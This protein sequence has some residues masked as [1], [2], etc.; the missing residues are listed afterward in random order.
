MSIDGTFSVRRWTDE[1][2]PWTKQYSQF[3]RSIKVMLNETINADP[4]F[5]HGANSN[6]GYNEIDNNGRQTN[7]PKAVNTIPKMLRNYGCKVIENVIHAR[8]NISRKKIIIAK[9]NHTKKTVFRN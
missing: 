3:R 5:T 2:R 6:M 4:K 1:S 9:K 7:F 8:K